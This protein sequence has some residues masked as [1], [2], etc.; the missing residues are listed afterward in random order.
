ML[1]T[2]GFSDLGD[3]VND[4]EECNPKIQIHIN[5]NIRVDLLVFMAKAI[6]RYD[7]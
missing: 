6:T 4:Q 5:Q 3:L 2:S 1:G 7:D